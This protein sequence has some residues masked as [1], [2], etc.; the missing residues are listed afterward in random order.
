MVMASFALRS[1]LF[2]LIHINHTCHLP[3]VVLLWPLLLNLHH[4]LQLS[5]LF[6]KGNLKLYRESK[7]INFQKLFGSG[8]MEQGSATSLPVSCQAF[9]HSFESFPAVLPQ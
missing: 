2:G 5:C 8:I 9:K 4:S 1:I 3:S 7:T 6:R